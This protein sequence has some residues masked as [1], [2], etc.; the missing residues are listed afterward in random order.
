MF[1]ATLKTEFVHIWSG[2]PALDSSDSRFSHEKWMET[3]D[4]SHLCIR[5]GHNPMRFRLRRLDERARAHIVDMYTGQGAA[6]IVEAFAVGV[7]GFDHVSCDGTFL[8]P[9]FVTKKNGIRSLADATVNILGQ[10]EGLIT[11]VGLRVFQESAGLK[12]K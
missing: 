11:E 12:K 9:E 2:D 8:Q 1:T 10:A 5:P 7:I 3:G 4:D 6:S